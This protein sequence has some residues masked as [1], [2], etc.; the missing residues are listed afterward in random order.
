M[1][2]NVLII[3]ISITLIFLLI[4]V[5]FEYERQYKI[6]KNTLWLQVKNISSDIEN[7]LNNLKNDINRQIY[8]IG[9]TNDKENVIVEN[10]KEQFEKLFLKYYTLIQNINIYDYERNIINIS[11]NNKNEIII[12]R[13]IAQRQINLERKESI[14]SKDGNINYLLPIYLKNNNLFANA[15]VT[16]NLYKYIT[17]N[18][19]K[20]SVKFNTE[21]FIIIDKNGNLITN[22]KKLVESDI[23]NLKKLISSNDNYFVFKIDKN[24]NFLIKDIEF[25][26][27]KTK[28]IFAYAP[29]FQLF[30][31]NNYS[32]LLTIFFL[33][34]I[35]E[36]LIIFIYKIKLNDR[37]KIKELQKKID[38]LKNLYDTVPI[39]IIVYNNER[40]VIQINKA[41]LK[42]LYIDSIE[43]IMGQ[44]ISERFLQTKGL[45]N[46]QINAFDSNKFML[47]QKQGN[48]IIVYK[49]E[50]FSIINGEDLFIEA[51]ID[52]TPL[53]KARRYEASANLAK[54][55][56]LA[57]MSHEI[58]TPM[59]G[60]IG[61]INAFNDENLSEKQKEN[62][63]IIK[64]SAELLL[65]IIDD[66]LDFSK[67]EAGKMS[68][69]E[70]PFSLKE[71]INIAI[72][73]F[74]QIIKEKNLGLELH[75]ENEVPDKLIGDPYRLRQILINLISNS[76][77]FTH[78]GKIL[79]EVKLI[80]KYN[81]NVTLYFSV[82]DTGIGIPKNKLE[83]I[84]NTFTQ[85]EDSVS[86]KYGGSG[87]GTTICKQLVNLMNGEIWVE[88]PSGISENKN[89]PG[90]RFSFTVELYSN[91]G[92]NKNLKFEDIKCFKDIKALVIT[93]INTVN[94]YFKDFIES[95]KIDYT[96]FDMDFR[97]YEELKLLIKNKNSFHIII[98]IDEPNF[99]AMSLA[100]KL[101]EEDLLSKNLV[102]I[103]STNHKMHN[104]IVAKK[105]GADYYFTLP[106]RR[107][108]FV[109]TLY[110]N[111]PS[112]NYDYKIDSIKLKEKLSILI[113]EDNIINQRVAQTI[114]E[115]L[116]YKIDI[117]NNGEEA[118]QMLE[119]NNYDI[120][121]MDLVMPEK[122]GIQATVEIRG[123]GYKTPI[124]AMTANISKSIRK[125]AI[126]AGM[127]DYILK[128]VKLEDVKNILIKWT[129]N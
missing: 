90:A 105:S 100:K 15:I 98:L 95:Y 129:T 91:E 64:K 5:I 116:G 43:E 70:I 53:E 25:S 38:I 67:I 1:K 45:Y 99:N 22:Y 118:L 81:G 46:S 30:V 33:F 93:K 125:Q 18:L 52:I 49:K 79:I 2:K 73:L 88:S 85:A 121:F 4:I 104:Y 126:D 97:S 29:Y 42:L 31:K 117:A 56:F 34:V 110:Q 78:E 62:L 19:N 107:D 3:L 39:G 36:I 14:T 20:Y 16:I 102:Y 7:K 101:N 115:N 27:L 61:M 58:R 10:I 66:I 50:A 47:Y 113:A 35:I 59:N 124:I 23:R 109:E 12:D 86:R 74:K 89:Y 44:N 87:L 60:I 63:Q 40:K 103:L 94:E 32:Y 123:K 69:E 54:S 17:E 112:I 111:F 80:E 57:K 71:E 128:P 37:T 68:L 127:N 72:D 75:I 11:L 6:Y 55:E 83:S 119:I 84:F 51:F 13:Y 120:I 77:K 9:T 26:T 24:Y 41:A 82:A 114:F 65:N 106:F 76:V 21:Y 108:E 8:N 122:D 28:I 96:I 92:L 48:E